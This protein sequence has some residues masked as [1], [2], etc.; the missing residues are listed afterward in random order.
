[1]HHCPKC[2]SPAIVEDFR[3]DGVR[4]YGC[5]KCFHAWETVEVP[6][7]TLKELLGCSLR[8]TA[9]EGTAAVAEPA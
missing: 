3:E 8:L 6:S 9:L 1:M 2:E 5:T 4:V 7:E